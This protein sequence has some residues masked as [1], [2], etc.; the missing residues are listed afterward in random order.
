VIMHTNYFP[1]GH[2]CMHMQPVGLLIS[3]SAI[4]FLAV[5]YSKSGHPES[6]LSIQSDENKVITISVHDRWRKLK[7]FAFHQAFVKENL[8]SDVNIFSESTSSACTE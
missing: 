8:S 1:N 5:S 4:N 3:Q 2:V 7:N 6:H